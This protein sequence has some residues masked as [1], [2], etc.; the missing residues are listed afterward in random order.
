VVSDRFGG[1]ARPL[2]LP[3]PVRGRISF[4]AEVSELSSTFTPGPMVEL[5]A[6]FFT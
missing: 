4:Y 6:T 2:P 3:A 5:S 1:E